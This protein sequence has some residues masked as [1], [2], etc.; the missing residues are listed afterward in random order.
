MCRY[1]CIAD[2]NFRPFHFMKQQMWRNKTQKH[3]SAQTDGFLLL[4]DVLANTHCHIIRETSVLQH[5]AELCW[6]ETN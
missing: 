4:T 3:G 6:E 5:F 2:E 1:A